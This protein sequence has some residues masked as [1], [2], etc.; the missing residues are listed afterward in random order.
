MRKKPVATLFVLILTLSLFAGCGTKT[1]DNEETLVTVEVETPAPTEV[2]TP[3]AT[4][5][6]E[7]TSEVTSEV[8]ETPKTTETPK[9]TETPKTTETPEP[10]PVATTEP[11]E[12]PE[13]E[14]TVIEVVELSDGNATGTE[15]RYSDGTSDYQIS[16]VG[17]LGTGSYEVK[18]LES[19][20]VIRDFD[21]AV[22]LVYETQEDEIYR[23]YA[24][25]FR[26]W[27]N[28]DEMD[29]KNLSDEAIMKLASP[30]PAPATFQR[31][32][33][34]TAYE[35]IVQYND[36]PKQRKGWDRFV[37]NY[38]SGKAYNVWVENLPT[39]TY[40]DVDTLLE[41]CKSI[42]IIE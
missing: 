16:L 2:E 34:E 14:V 11:T 35:A 23:G 40:P 18:G 25:Y 6:S 27:D 42:N 31:I 21:A 20:M 13:P 15:T 5:T 3:E 7:K 1:E 24:I 17:T 8:T 28:T 4:E 32:E 22:R 29:L 38:E 36:E 37:N 30:V 10:T 39:S 26:P 33:T 9:P 12:T 41:I 19:G